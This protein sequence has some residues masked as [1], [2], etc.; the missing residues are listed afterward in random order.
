MLREEIEKTDDVARTQLGEIQLNRHQINKLVHVQHNLREDLNFYAMWVA[1]VESNAN[2]K[3]REF[4][5]F[6]DVSHQNISFLG[7]FPSIYFHF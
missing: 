1:G 2:K 7:C 6:L 5:N 4:W 3:S